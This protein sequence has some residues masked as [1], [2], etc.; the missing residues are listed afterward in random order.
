VA[1]LCTRHY[2]RV[3]DILEDGWRAWLERGKVGRW[4]RWVWS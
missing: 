1:T 2:K 4:V 3:V